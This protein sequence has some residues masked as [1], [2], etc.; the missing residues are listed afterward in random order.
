MCKLRS[1]SCTFNTTPHP[2]EPLLTAGQFLPDLLRYLEEPLSYNCAGCLLSAHRGVWKGKGGGPTFH[3]HL[4][5]AVDSLLRGCADAPQAT[6]EQGHL[7]PFLNFRCLFSWNNANTRMDFQ[8]LFLGMFTKFPP[9]VK[10]G[11]RG[12][13]SC[14]GWADPLPCVG[15]GGLTAPPRKHLGSSPYQSSPFPSC[16]IQP[17]PPPPLGHRPAVSHVPSATCRFHLP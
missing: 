3:L 1:E 17:R 15:R 8:F 13:T 5:G 4:R 2:P 7:L 16:A 9:G 12:C 6:I 14:P 11:G 10:G